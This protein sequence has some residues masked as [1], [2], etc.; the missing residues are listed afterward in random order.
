MLYHMDEVLCVYA[1]DPVKIE[2]RARYIVQ[3][4]DRPRFSLP[5]PDLRTLT[6]DSSD[7]EIKQILWEFLYL[8]FS[9][10][11]EANNPKIQAFFARI[12][13]LRLGI[14]LTAS[15][16]RD[17]GVQMVAN[18][19]SNFSQLGKAKPG[20]ALFGR[21]KN[22]PAIICG[23]SPSLEKEIEILRL[24]KERALIFAGGAAL[25]VLAAHEFE[26]HF[27]AAIDPHPLRGNL[28]PQTIPF[29]YQNRV[30]P[31]LLA[32]MIGPR[33]WMAGNAGYPLDEWMLKES[34]LEQTFSSGWNVATFSAAI[35]TALGCSPI[36]FVGLE[37]S[38]PTENV[39]ASGLEEK[40]SGSF[41]ETRDLHGQKVFTKPDWQVAGSWLEE[42]V[43]EHPEVQFFN[44]TRGGLP[45]PS[46]PRLSLKGVVASYPCW[47]LPS[48]IKQAIDSLPSIDADA[49][50]TVCKT[51]KS[52][53][54]RCM[55]LCAKL[56]ALYAK[57]HPYSPKITGEGALCEVELEEEL[58]YKIFLAPVWEIW[59]P[60]FLREEGDID[61]HRLLFF[62]R[63]LGEI[64]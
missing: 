12:E 26:P 57:H 34:G 52:S 25:N 16:F 23:A 29:F 5:S 31:E 38:T 42:F 3:V 50:E 36:F 47:D 21:F 54:E 27:G 48:S 56:L 6:L 7:E 63:I 44:A 14:H 40:V 60:L 41:V 59:R 64:L 30:R 55:S 33:L 39:Y 61:L 51:V 8:R 37:L 17:G 53:L 10:Q 18:T 32:K 49:A 28:P 2:S 9:Y 45:L 22:R 1:E 13:E 24:W 19:L 46:I 11:N 62:K 20:S 43:K 58:A 4:H 15:D 35:A